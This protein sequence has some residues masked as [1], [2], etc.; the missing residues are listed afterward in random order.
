[1]KHMKRQTPPVGFTLVELLLALS[2]MAILMASVAAAMHAS[3]QS[4][5][6]NDDYADITQSARSIMTKMGHEIR[7]CEDVAGTAT[8]LV[9]LPINDGS[10]LQQIQ[11]EIVGGTLFYRKV[12]NGVTTAYPLLDGTDQVKANSLTVTTV[13][14]LDSGG[15]AC[16]VD[17]SVKLVLTINNKTL[18]VTASGCPRRN[19]VY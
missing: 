1:M 3:F 2:L 11:Y 9:L 4:Y 15:Q 8:K 16:V 14:G 19:Q 5:S 10:G 18:S 6:E 17:V 7:S 12:V 13:N